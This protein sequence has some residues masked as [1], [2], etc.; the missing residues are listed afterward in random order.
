MV[1]SNLVTSRLTRRL[2]SLGTTAVFSPASVADPEREP[3]A[4]GSPR[5]DRRLICLL[6]RSVFSGNPNDPFSITPFPSRPP[7]PSLKATPSAS[8]SAAFASIPAFAI[9]QASASPASAPVPA[10]SGLSADQPPLSAGVEVPAATDEP[11]TTKVA[12]DEHVKTESEVLETAAQPTSKT[13]VMEVDAT[14]TYDEP[15][16][17]TNGAPA[18]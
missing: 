13:S 14:A 7:S 12:D 1:G 11:T 17:Q 18:E 15:A 16:T 10:P 4:K 8:T 3:L 9:D 6:I 2:Y 5:P